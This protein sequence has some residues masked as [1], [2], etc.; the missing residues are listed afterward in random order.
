LHCRIL[1]FF[2]FYGSLMHR[3]RPF[4]AACYSGL[5]PNALPMI[6]TYWSRSANASFGGPGPTPARDAARSKRPI[7]IHLARGNT[8][9]LWSSHI[10]RLAGIARERHVH[11]AHAKRRGPLRLMLSGFQN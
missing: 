11:E 7:Q 2:F 1:P 3:H 9:P 6:K 5:R 8:V 10:T 4:C